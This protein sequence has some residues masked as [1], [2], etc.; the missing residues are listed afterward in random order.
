VLS[1]EEFSDLVDFVRYGLLDPRILPEHLRTFIPRRVP[2]GSQ[3]LAFEFGE[4]H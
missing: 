1:D 2:S 4:E 3:T